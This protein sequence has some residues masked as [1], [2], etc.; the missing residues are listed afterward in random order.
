MLNSL[1]QT[2]AKL[3]AGGT[4]SLTSTAQ[5]DFSRPG[6]RRGENVEPILNLYLYDIRESKQ[7]QHSRRQVERQQWDGTQ[8]GKAPRTRVSWSADWFDVSLVVT[9][10]SST[11]LGECHLLSEAMDVLLKYRLLREEHLEP[12]LR[13]YGNLSML[14]STAPPIELGALWSALSLPIRPAIYL[15]VTVPFSSP[16]SQE[17]DQVLERRI[18]TFASTEGGEANGE[19]QQLR[20]RVSV[21]GIVVDATDPHN[22]RPLPQTKVTVEGWQDLSTVSDH[23]G[24]FFFENLRNGPYRLKLQRDHYLPRDCD[25]LVEE[26]LLPPKTVALIPRRGSNGAEDSN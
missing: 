22:P 12:Q 3:L 24:I 26:N 19:P 10:W 4:T 5:I 9:A 16:I 2:L 20:R 14:V 17:R 23:E 6:T 7:V 13:G 15:T 25:V 18:A 1:L 11:A 21:A 8:N